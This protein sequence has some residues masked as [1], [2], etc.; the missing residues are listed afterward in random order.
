MEPNPFDIFEWR[1]NV[2][3]CQS[4]TIKGELPSG[5]RVIVVE[6]DGIERDITDEAEADYFPGALESRQ[7]WCFQKGL[8]LRFVL[9]DRM[10]ETLT[11]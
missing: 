2:D 10:E 6:R 4:L 11:R 9:G 1:S 7:S 8:L 5:M 3:A